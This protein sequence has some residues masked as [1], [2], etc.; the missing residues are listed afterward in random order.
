MARQG[1]SWLHL[2][3]GFINLQ[4]MWML[5]PSSLIHKQWNEQESKIL[6]RDILTVREWWPGTTQP[7]MRRLPLDSF[8]LQHFLFT[9]SGR[10]QSCCGW[11]SHDVG[12][13]ILRNFR[14]ILEEIKCGT[15]PPLPPSLPA[16]SLWSH[17]CLWTLIFLPGLSR[18]WTRSQIWSTWRLT[19]QMEVSA[20]NTFSH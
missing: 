7:L 20:L 5:P 15:K 9:G 8:L 19:H 10:A 11:A 3:N 18:V 17:I 13:G 14:V 12:F 4:G 1:S 2:D 16:C 6:P